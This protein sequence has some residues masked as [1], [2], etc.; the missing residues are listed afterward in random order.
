LAKAPKARFFFHSR[1]KSVAWLARHM[2]S[3]H[4]SCWRPGLPNSGVDPA[5]DERRI[6]NQ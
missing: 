1:Q 6:G 2:R 4:F 3:Q 5:P